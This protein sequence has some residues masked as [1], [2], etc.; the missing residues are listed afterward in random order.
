MRGA[1]TG[2]Y[3]IMF[4]ALIAVVATSVISLG[5]L[6]VFQAQTAEQKYAQSV[7]DEIASVIS[8]ISASPDGAYYVLEPTRTTYN[9]TVTPTRVIVERGLNE[10]A[11]STHV[12]RS[13]IPIRF[14]STDALC[15]QKSLGKILLKE[16]ECLSCSPDDGFCDQ[17]CDALGKCD[18]DCIK[19]GDGY[20]SKSCA[21]LADGKCDLDCVGKF[22]G[23]W[24]PD[25]GCQLTEPDKASPRGLCPSGPCSANQTCDIDSGVLD[26]AWDPCCTST[27]SDGVC[28]PDYDAGCDPDCV[29]DRTCRGTCASDPSVCFP[30]CSNPACQR[31]R[32]SCA[33]G[34][35]SKP[36][37]WDS[38][39]PC[40]GE[41]PEYKSNMTYPLFLK[42]APD[43][44]RSNCS[45]NAT[46][47]ELY[48]L[49]KRVPV[50]GF[51][52]RGVDYI[53]YTPERIGN[54]YA[55]FGEGTPH[56]TLLSDVLA[57]NGT[58]IN[59]FLKASVGNGTLTAPIL[60]PNDTVIGGRWG[61]YE[62]EEPSAK[63]TTSSNVTVADVTTTSGDKRKTY[64]M[65]TGLPGVR[66]T[67]DYDGASF[68]DFP[69]NYTVSTDGSFGYA[70][71][72]V[73]LM[74]YCKGANVLSHETIRK[75]S[76]TSQEAW[77]I[78]CTTQCAGL[79]EWLLNDHEVEVVALG[80]LTNATG[81][82]PLC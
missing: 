74:L 5:R 56:E 2:E 11:V 58:L 28:D 66:M 21:A 67:S 82:S 53:V 10:Q 14:N 80:P 50:G 45:I 30:S 3:L 62:D 39:L 24:D 32:S 59:S 55:Y 22:D 19:S 81:Y 71:G 73:T 51:Y 44:L 49:G 54:L 16:G 60:L 78:E 6:I 33:P 79:K 75:L 34:C 48:H 23:I 42:M 8:E 52:E 26:F 68:W 25:C 43:L 7:A 17:G 65:F 46:Q 12:G 61:Y 20:C 47:V 1:S 40:R 38:A 36:T 9:I 31:C 77:I 63:T 57:V 41:L 27:A 4:G 29:T 37:G 13:V 64:Q 69:A 70:R 72:D 18:P 76:C 15:I 35:S